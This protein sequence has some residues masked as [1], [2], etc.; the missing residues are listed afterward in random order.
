MTLNARAA[1]PLAFATI[2]LVL[3]LGNAAP[4]TAQVVPLPPNE[5]RPCQPYPLCLVVPDPRAPQPNP[6]NLD[7]PDPDAPTLPLQDDPGHAAHLKGMFTIDDG[8]GRDL[9]NYDLF[10][11]LPS[12]ISNPMPTIWLWLANMGF[13]VGK[14]ALGFSVWFTEWSMTAGVVDWIK[15]PAQDLEKVWQTTIIGGLKLR[16]LALL[17]ATGYLGLLFMRGL[18]TRAWRETVSTIAINVLA[19]AV[20]THPVDFLVGDGGV[21]SLS[22]DLGADVS[23][24]IM[25]KQP[26]G[27]GN[28]AAP[29]GQA[30][31]DNL[32][33]APWETLNYG[34]PVSGKQG[35]GACQYSIKQILD[36]G[37]WSGKDSTPARE[38]AGCPSEY[39]KYNEVADGDRML[40]AWE[41]AVAMILFAILTI[42]LNAIQ[43]LAPYFLL[44]EGLLLS[45]AL[46][47]ALIP[48]LQHQL[49][50]RIGSIA[51]TIA[52]LLMGMFFIAVM[53]V[54]LRS[55][56][57]AD[58]GPQLVKFAVIDIVVFSGFLFRKRL[59]TN[60]Q[61]IRSSVNSGVQRLGRPRSGPKSMPLPVV[62]PGPHRISRTIK[63]GAGAFTEAIAPAND[64]KNRLVTAGKLGGKA[65]SKAVSFTLGAPVSWPAAA[66]RARTALTARG[67]A[68]KA[69]L[70]RKAGAVKAY[71][72][73]YA[74][75][76]GAAASPLVNVATTAASVLGS[77]RSSNEQPVAPQPPA[78]VSA[79]PDFT[80]TDLAAP[81]PAGSRPRGKC[82]V[83]EPTALPPGM[84]PITP[85]WSQRLR[86]RLNEHRS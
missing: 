6:P 65:S 17:I 84:L 13:A 22:R 41:Y 33:I 9:R 19:I 64:L 38:L 68:A 3:L 78:R 1:K 43:I 20:I 47:A 2:V 35:T 55:L 58:L 59:M 10:A 16:E 63:T 52:K 27:T 8:Y 32:L 42:C 66:N 80:G 85:T 11:N 31:I 57:L 79:T 28:P 49:A 25:G 67:T 60:I 12:L 34:A 73:T 61:R 5:P 50:Y 39:G 69:T 37:P 26:G 23:A 18:T 4:A 21:L 54:L 15:A 82:P 53:T 70:G 74:G 30:L 48:T 86:T 83:P 45:L 62:E 51:G 76:I 81:A 7:H 56:M 44:F 24:V 75:N 40:G 29:I 77:H 72:S 46:I 14:Y 36:Q 71:A